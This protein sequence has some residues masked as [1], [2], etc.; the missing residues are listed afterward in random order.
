LLVEETDERRV[1]VAC[2]FGSRGFGFNVANGFI[3]LVQ[4]RAWDARPAGNMM[5]P[6][7]VIP[8]SSSLGADYWEAMQ[9]ALR[10]A[11]AGRDYVIAQVLGLLGNP[12]VL[13]EVHNNHNDA[14]KEKHA[15]K[16]LIVIRK[17]ATP[18]WPGQMGF[19]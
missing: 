13:L 9:L 2:H 5:R 1:W 11:Y 7:S 19:I 18:L 4:G 3:N 15:G 12:K 8:L 6:P 14:R 17:G 16:E 10:Y